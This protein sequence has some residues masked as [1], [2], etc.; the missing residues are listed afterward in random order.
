MDLPRLP[1]TDDPHLPGRHLLALPEGIDSEEVEVLAASRFAAARWE[2]LGD[3]PA[4]RGRRPLTA[5]FGIRI[6]AAPAAPVLRL[7]RHSTLT[8]PYGVTP[9]DL[10]ALGLPGATGQVYDVACT[11]ERGEKPYPGGDRDGINRAFADG[12]PVRE[13]QRVVQWLVDA[14]RRLGGSVRVGGRGTILAP[15]IEGAI[16]LTVLTDRWVEP[17]QALAIVQSAVPRARLSVPPRAWDGPLEGAGRHG[18][19][20]APHGITEP[21]GRGL[22]SALDQ[23]GVRDPEERRRLLAEAAAFDEMMLSTPQAVETFGVLVDLG[24]DGMIAVEVGEPE[25]VPP[26]LQ[27]VEWAQRGVVAYRIHWEPVV[28]DELEAERPTLEHRVARR[29][30]ASTMHAV[31]RA[32]HQAVGGEIADE[33]DFLVD[34]RDL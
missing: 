33:A 26:L 5:A 34:P 13:E 23:H 21:G 24:V 7:S 14:A 12:L 27:A 29:R 2:P 22:R 18:V 6:T 4:Q 9:D 31:A 32:V 25:E 16:D 15:D 10:V 1:L 17:N 11:R 3:V 19:G 8:G 28:V 30:A 20:D